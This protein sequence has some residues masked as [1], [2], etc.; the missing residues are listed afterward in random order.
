M[1]LNFVKVK[2]LHG[3]NPD[4]TKFVLSEG[5]N[6]C[7]KLDLQNMSLTFFDDLMK[8]YPDGWVEGQISHISDAGNAIRFHVFPSTFFLLSHK[9]IL[10]VSDKQPN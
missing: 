10:E 7:L 2:E 1:K 3:T 6:V 4:G 8:Q 5:D 9:D